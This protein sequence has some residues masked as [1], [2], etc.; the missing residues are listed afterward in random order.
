MGDSTRAHAEFEK[1]ASSQSQYRLHSQICLETLPRLA[2]GARSWSTTAGH[3]A[4]E[5]RFFDINSNGS[6]VAVPT[7]TSVAVRKS[8]RVALV[9]GNSAYKNVPAL[10][11]PQHDAEAIATASLRYRFQTVTLANDLTREKVLSIPFVSSV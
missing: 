4:V 2:C 3:F 9:I 7:A 1:A 8:R 6:G 5:G 10:S 11:N